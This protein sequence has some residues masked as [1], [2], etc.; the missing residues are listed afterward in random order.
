MLTHVRFGV[1]ILSLEIF[2]D[3]GILILVP[4]AQPRIVVSYLVAVDLQDLRLFLS[5]GRF[6]SFLG[7]SHSAQR[8][9]GKKG[10]GNG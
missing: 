10:R 4:I 8:N 3:L 6:Y 2:D 5:Y 1:S 7:N 9:H